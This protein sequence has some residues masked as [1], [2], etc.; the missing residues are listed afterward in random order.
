MVTPPS[1]LSAR[2][3]PA[4][5]ALARAIVPETSGL[6]EPGWDSFERHFES[7]LPD[8][9]AVR[10]QIRAFLSLLG[11]LARVR[12][13]KAL[14]ALGPA[15]TGRLLSAMA[16]SRMLLLRR[17]VWGVRT[18]VFLGYY[19]DESRAAA[20]GYRASPAGWSAR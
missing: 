2:T 8:R 14:P 17:G 9:P 20:L 18:L 11:F 1:L 13:G 3:R 7:G 19:G 10:R 5:R 6:D 15:E 16:A 4:I 12:F